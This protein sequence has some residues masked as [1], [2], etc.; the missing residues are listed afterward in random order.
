MCLQ[1]WK[2]LEKQPERNLL[3]EVYT[4]KEVCTMEKEV[5]AEQGDVV[6]ILDANLT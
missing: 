1:V 3:E 4:T 2:E 6:D 5:W